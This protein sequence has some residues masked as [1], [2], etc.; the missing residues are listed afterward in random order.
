MRAR[1]T[2]RGCSGADAAL[3]SGMTAMQIQEAL[4]QAPAHE[5]LSLAAKLIGAYHAEQD[6][7]EQRTRMNRRLG[8]R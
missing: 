7:E 1:A 2:S 6:A 3:R 8:R 5:R 4:L